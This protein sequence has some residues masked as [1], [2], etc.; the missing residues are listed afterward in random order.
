MRWIDNVIWLENRNGVRG[1]RPHPICNSSDA[2]AIVICLG[3]NAFNE[4][5][6][7]SMKNSKP[8]DFAGHVSNPAIC[9]SCEIGNSGRIK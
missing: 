2:V 7:W 6:L 9:L 1:S 8:K 5:V 3:M 4:L